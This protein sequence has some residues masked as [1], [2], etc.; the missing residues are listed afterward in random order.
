MSMNSAHSRLKRAE[1]DLAARWEAT[2]QYW[3]DENARQFAKEYLDPLLD[4]ARAAHDAMVHL[5]TV[6]TVLRHD[7]E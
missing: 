6:L 2:R 1:K 5:E 7:C 4:R 3:H